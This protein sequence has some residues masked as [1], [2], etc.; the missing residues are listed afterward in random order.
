MELK[1]IDN[2]SDFYKLLKDLDTEKMGIEIMKQ[3]MNLNLIYI[4]NIKS[5][6]ANI[7]KQDALSIGA[8]LA[9]PFGAIDCS[10][11]YVDSILI[12]NDRHI[13]KLIIKESHQP[14]GLKEFSKKLKD[15]LVDNRF[16]T[17]IMGIININD[18]SFYKESRFKG[19]KAIEQIEKFINAGAN[20]IDIGAISSRPNSE[21]ISSDEELERVKEIIDEIYKLKLYEKITFSI[22]SYRERV[23]RYALDRGFK[24]IND[25]TGLENDNVARV[26]G[27]FKA[28][29]IIMHMQNS[30]KD[31]QINPTYEDVIIEIDKFFE[32]RIQKAQEFDIDNIILDVGIG[33]GK[34]LEHNLTL[35]KHL[36]HFKKFGYEL[37]IGASRKSLIDSII[38]TPI[39]ERLAGTLA[40]HL[41]SIENGA[42]IIRCHDV[43][44][45]FQAIKV[46]EAIN[47]K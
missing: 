38:P 34:S 5:P 13:E 33:F 42:N 46:L 25:I 30:P 41:K 14:F 9:T 36:K 32:E 4:K 16:E 18:D 29:A 31:M 27:E 24:I 23:I 17:K 37:L 44:E 40:I 21:E 11:E 39:E 45:H 19:Y 28:T 8:E 26:I 1:K 35:I 47:S 10:K 43:Q 15:F 6:A 3:K 20:I 22:D 12:A 7:L 2:N